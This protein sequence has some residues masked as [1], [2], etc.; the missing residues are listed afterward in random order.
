MIHDANSWCWFKWFK[1]CMGILVSWVH[2][3]S[4]LFILFHIAPFQTFSILQPFQPFSLFKALVEEIVIFLDMPMARNKLQNFG[5]NDHFTFQA[6][7]V[8]LVKWPQRAVETAALWSAELWPIFSRKAI[9]FLSSCRWWLDRGTK[10][11]PSENNNQQTSTNNNK[12]LKNILTWDIHTIIKQV[13]VYVHPMFIPTSSTDFSWQN[14]RASQRCRVCSSKWCAASHG[15]LHELVRGPVG[16]WWEDDE[17]TW[18][19]DAIDIHRSW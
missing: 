7:F 16:R 2:C 12:H 17:K 14:D 15:D 6:E 8:E 3:L 5:V 18:E 19:D 9:Y 11:S 4:H 1:L 10:K 13:H